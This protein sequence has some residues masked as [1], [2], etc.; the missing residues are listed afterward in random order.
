MGKEMLNK[1]INH[2]TLHKQWQGNHLLMEIYPKSP[3]IIL[4]KTIPSSH[5]HIFPPSLPALRVSV[6]SL[7]G[8]ILFPFSL[9]SSLGAPAIQDGGLG[10]C[11]QPMQGIPCS[12]LPSLEWG[13]M[14]L[15]L[16]F[17]LGA[18]VKYSGP[19]FDQAQ[20]KCLCGIGFSTCWVF[21]LT[22]VNKR[23]FCLRGTQ[24]RSS[25]FL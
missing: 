16:W 20:A 19:L 18:W 13:H 23:G 7:S 4:S 2:P 3:K 24:A 17:S 22:E 15:F 9:V 1:S 5:F 12:P 11:A 25:S 14:V 6:H 8:F 21:F 10:S